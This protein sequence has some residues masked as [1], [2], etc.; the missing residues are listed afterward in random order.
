MALR[1]DRGSLRPAKTLEDGRVIAEAHIARIGIQEYM[2][3]DGSIRRELRLPEEVFSAKSMQ[4][5]AMLPLTSSHPTEKVTTDNARMY[6]VGASAEKV[7]RDD[8]HL[9]TKLMFADQP[10]IDDMRS[11][12]KFDVSCGYTCD[13]DETPG[14][15]PVYGE[16]HAIQRNITGNH[17]AANIWRGR[18][19]SA[20]VRMDAGERKRMLAAA[21]ASSALST[22]GKRRKALHLDGAMVSVPR[23]DAV[24]TNAVTGHQHLVELQPDYGDRMSGT[25]SWS[26][27]VGSDGEH[28][29]AW[30][31]NADGTID[32]A[33]SEGHTHSIEDISGMDSDPRSRQDD[34]Q[35]APVAPLPTSRGRKMP[36]TVKKPEIKIDEKAFAT[37]LVK[38]EHRADAAEEALDGEKKRADA[39]EGRVAALEVEIESLK[40]NRLDEKEIQSRDLQIE[41]L[42]KKLGKETSR[43]DAALDPEYVGK[44]VRRRVKIIGAAEAIMGEKYVNDASTIDDLELMAAVVE[45]LHNVDIRKDDE[46]NT[47]SIEYVT[48]RFDA[49][50]DGFMSGV[51][52]LDRLR[53]VARTNR[54]EEPRVDSNTARGE[55][56]QRQQNAWRPKAASK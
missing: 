30:I 12:K 17:I 40:K 24:L 18:A 55:Y 32:I 2:N 51:D 11:N 39:A 22:N 25:T 45:K 6:M 21:V 20:R 29:H 3:D 19:G 4:S 26:K 13:L 33:E 28:A 47:R 8:D 44:K 43:A 52:T 7:E 48:A 50:V 1:V 54:V 31:R 16:Y 46:G 15:H 35:P 56:I 38:A 27:S 53:E 42:T 36:P 41:A 49:A 14:V 5:F 23:V 37:E 9:L 10:T 34:V